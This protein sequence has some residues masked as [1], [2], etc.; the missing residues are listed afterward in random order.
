MPRHRP[1]RLSPLLLLLLLLGGCGFQLRG[2]GPAT[3]PL[4]AD[5]SPLQL[6][7]L[8][9]SDPTRAELAM[10]LRSSGVTLAS[11]GA[12]AASVLQLSDRQSRRRVIAVDSD[13]KVL[14]YELFESLQ[15]ELRDGAGNSR[16]QAQRVAIERSHLN[17]GVQV[18]G[19]ESE[20]QTLRREMRRDLAGQIVNRLAAQ[21]R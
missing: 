5:L 20:E 4:P 8:V 3:T 15:F 14:E 18:L 13:G 7:G 11:G 12:T 19:K 16:L 1:R 21:L 2:T 17:P 6:R 10:L 9:A